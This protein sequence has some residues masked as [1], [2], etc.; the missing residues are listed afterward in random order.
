[1]ADKSYYKFG[2]NFEGNES[3]N[4]FKNVTIRKRKLLSLTSKDRRKD[5]SSI[6]AKI[7]TDKF[8]KGEAAKD[9]FSNIIKQILPESYKR[10]KI[11]YDQSNNI[12]INESWYESDGDVSI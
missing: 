7:P 10:F 5:F 4:K 12:D 3:I 9:V 2:E 11:D 8:K 1:M 6:Y